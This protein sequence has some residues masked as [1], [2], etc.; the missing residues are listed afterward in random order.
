MSQTENVGNRRRYP[1]H[2]SGTGHNTQHRAWSRQI[3]PCLGSL[4]RKQTQV[5]SC[6]ANTA[7]IHLQIIDQRV[8]S[9]LAPI[10][11]LS[12]HLPQITRSL[13]LVLL[14]SYSSEFQNLRVIVTLEMSSMVLTLNMQ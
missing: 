4:R 5:H 2:L 7:L 8:Q 14:Q 3:E 1:L 10:P 9:L 12:P 11:H 6:S 13:I